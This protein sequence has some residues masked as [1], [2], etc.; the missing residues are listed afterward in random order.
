MAKGPVAKGLGRAEA[1]SDA[2]E[3]ATALAELDVALGT[4]PHNAAVSTA[5]GWR[6]PPC[7]S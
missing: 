2:G 4:E 6:T 1:L 7:R 5:R 3:Y